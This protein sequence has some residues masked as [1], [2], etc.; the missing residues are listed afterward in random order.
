MFRSV[1]F[2]LQVCGGFFNDLLLISSL[3]PLWSDNRHSMTFIK[4]R[5]FL[6][7]VVWSILVNVPCEFQKSVYSAVFEVIYKCQLYPGD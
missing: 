4:L 5:C 1:L 7:L 6:W 3:I 2:D